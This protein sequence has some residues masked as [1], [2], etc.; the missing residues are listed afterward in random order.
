MQIKQIQHIGQISR[1][2]SQTHNEI[3]DMIIQSY[4]KRQA[5]NDRIAENFSQY[6]RGVDEYYNPMERRPVEL[7][8]GYQNAWTN[9]LGEYIL[10]DD[11]NFNPNIGSTREWQKMELKKR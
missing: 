9:R 10:S 1:I 3:S 8:S 5:V 2:I 6:I 7:P 11:P 4:N